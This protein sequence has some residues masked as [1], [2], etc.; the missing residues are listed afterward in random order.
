MDDKNLKPPQ[1]GDDA[2]LQQSYPSPMVD[3][4]EAQYYEQLTQHRELEGNVGHQPAQAEHH[5]LPSI[6]QHQEPQD[7]HHELHRLQELQEPSTT[8]QQNA[9]AAAN[10]AEELQLTAQLTRE[11]APMMAAGVEDQMQGQQPMPQQEPPAQQ[12]GEA[13]PDL[14]QQ[15]QASLQN[16][17][18]EMQG[19]EH[20]L[21][22]HHQQ[23]QHEHQQHQHQHDLQSHGLQDMLPHSGQP[24]PAP[25]PPPPPAPPHPNLPHHMSMGHHLPTAPH[26]PQYHLPGA[27][28]PRKRTK[29]SRACDECRRKKIKCD[30][31]T[32]ASEEPCSNCRRANTQ[33]LFSRVPQKRGPSKGYIKELADRINSIEG[34]LNTSVGGLERRL[35]SDTFASPG[36]PGDDTRKRPFSNISGDSFQTASPHRIPSI[37]TEHRPVMPHAHR[38]FSAS[39]SNIA[40]G[41]APRPLAPIQIGQIAG[42][43]NNVSSQGQSE[44]ADRTSHNEPARAPVQPADQLPDI[45]IED[46]VFNK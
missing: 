41:L 14:Q 12:P 34:K 13:E 3:S 7:E 46:A 11:L 10:A 29:V 38:D 42:E 8:Q 25:Y 23:H 44:M 43:T 33:C 18:R 24:Q 27:T 30:A 22:A 6:G 36:A 21:Q 37:S 4:A 20:V 39:D 35:S 26:Q 9:R 31:Q 17:E 28:P 2:P 5:G 1:E 19:H 32:E 45:D 40:N 15:L 16:H